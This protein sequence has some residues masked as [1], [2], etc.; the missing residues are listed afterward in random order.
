MR[1]KLAAALTAATVL[2]APAAAEGQTVSVRQGM[3]IVVGGAQCT[4]AFNDA[5]G[6][7]T[8]AHCGRTGDRVAVRTGDGVRE[9][10]TLYP[11][12]EYTTTST[13]NDWA[14]IQWDPGVRVWPNT[15]SGDSVVALEELRTGDS[16]CFY[17]P[18]AN[19]TRCSPF[20]GQ[21]GGNLYWG[22]ADARPG[23]SGAPVWAEGRGFVGILS[24]HSIIT[25][26][27]VDYRLL[28]ASAVGDR[29][30]PSAQ[31]EIDLL[32]RHYRTGPVG[33]Y[34]VVTP[35][36]RAAGA[37]A[38]IADRIEARAMGRLP[39]SSNWEAGTLGVIAALVIGTL[40][41]ATPALVQIIDIVRGWR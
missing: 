23:D 31:E 38:G 14:R 24:G 4:L 34:E 28:R 15:R 36:A 3:P 41:A 17:S 39:G 18:A 11:S 9:V 8:A 10:G 27:N 40:V 32:S 13:G 37:A 5:A 35:G 21:L 19:E 12:R 16:I 26:A 29:Q 30:S 33:E 25:S 6:G 22:D 20:A 7:Y 1:S 2:A